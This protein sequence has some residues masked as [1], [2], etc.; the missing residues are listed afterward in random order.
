MDPWAMRATRPAG[1]P[2]QLLGG[3]TEDGEGRSRR[4]PD[5]FVGEQVLI[6]EGHRP[7]RMADRRHPTDGIAGLVADEIGIR[8]AD[9][10]SQQG[11][12]RLL[13]DP[14]RAA[15]H[16]QHCP[17]RGLGAE[18]QGLGDLGHIAADLGRGLRG[19]AGRLGELDDLGLQAHLLEE[20]LHARRCR[21]Q[22]PHASPPAPGIAGSQRRWP[23]RTAA[24]SRSPPSGY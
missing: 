10:L 6:D 1:Q 17:V 4:G 7:G 11:R 19:T 8:F 13:I 23:G 24:G 21:P 3:Q 12:H 16:D 5:R 15:G 9:L 18:D 20:R 22:A 2:D 14:V